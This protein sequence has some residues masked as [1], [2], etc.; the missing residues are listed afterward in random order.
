MRTSSSLFLLGALGVLSAASASA[1][2]AVDTSKWTCESC[3]FEKAGVAATVD[4][5]VS[6]TSD[7]S[8][9]FGNLTGLR[10]KGAYLSLGGDMRWRDDGGLWA[11]AAGSTTYGNAAVEGGREGQFTLRLVYA[12]IPHYLS[13]DARTPFLGV[14]TGTLTLPAAYAEGF[15]TTGAMPLATTLPVDLSTTRQRLDLGANIAIAP[16][17]STRLTVRHDVR[18]GLQRTTGSFFSTAAQLAAPVDHTT[19]QIEL[20][21]TY[22]AAQWH[23]TLA[24]GVS[25]FRNGIDA[26]TWANPFKRV[27]D[28]AT[29]GQLALA[30][31]N[32]LHQVSGQ[33]AWLFSPAVRFSGDFAIGRL[34]QDE[35]F[36]STTLNSK[37]KVVA[38]QPTS[39]DGKV[40]TFNGNLRVTLTPL[41]NLRVNASYSRDV[42]DN[43]TP[44]ARYAMVATDMFV[45]GTVVNTPFSFRQDRFKL[46]ADFRGPGSLKLSAGVEENDINRSYQEVSD[47]REWT[48]WGKLSVR[49]SPKVWLAAKLSH[50]ERKNSGYGIAPWISP[51]ENP[52]MRKFN[53][54][55]RRRDSA[56]VRADFTV[57]EAVQF[58]FNADFA[59]DDYTR[60]PIGLN[61]ARSSGFGADL[62]VTVSDGLSLHAYVQTDRIRS[63][64]NGS[65]AFKAADWSGS[66]LD[67]TGVGGVGVKYQEGKL[68]IGADLT[69]ARTRSQAQVDM[70]AGAVPFPT[71]STAQDGLKLSASYELQKNLTLLGNYWFD[72][73]DAQDWRVDG[74]LPNTVPNLL[75]MGEQPARHRAH[76]VRLAV[77]YR[78]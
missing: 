28:G 33:A 78:F 5:G 19:D 29:R 31:D 22:N 66:T 16:R 77:R 14:G 2:A 11:N 51:P 6:A 35:P 71:A 61:Q 57:S 3:P 37:L 41:S 15:G 7:R 34:T 23:G 43:T 60:S 64:Q 45:G 8:A 38:L 32:Q 47:T 48:T 1:L 76:L 36:V 50:A 25:L 21:T 12:E 46:N 75:T 26:L 17:W 39:L 69:S 44:T 62:A 70:A 73:F 59:Y 18:D 55:D 9:R 49:P 13:D 27:V 67:S 65:Q 40:E 4:A 68:E 63:E 24:Y 54:A 53:L 72:R 30:P 58:G 74:I 52:L 10:R 56:R 42:R 20:S